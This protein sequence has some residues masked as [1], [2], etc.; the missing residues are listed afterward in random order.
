ML[1]WKSLK[2]LN[3]KKL[4]LLTQPNC[5]TLPGIIMEI[6]KIQNIGFLAH[7]Q[8]AVP[9]LSF[10]PPPLLGRAWVQGYILPSP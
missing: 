7:A 5:V 2:K 9:R 6:Y 8:T 10:P 3:T 4:H 1:T